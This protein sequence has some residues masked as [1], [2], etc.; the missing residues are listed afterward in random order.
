[1]STYQ[2]SVVIDLSR[3]ARV[4]YTRGHLQGGLGHHRRMPFV[5]TAKTVLRRAKRFPNQT[6]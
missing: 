5:S 6:P 4:L 1:M 3:V 2:C